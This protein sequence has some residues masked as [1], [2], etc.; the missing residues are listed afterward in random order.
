[1]RALARGLRQQ[2]YAVDIAADGEAGWEAG[3]VHEYDLVILDLNLPAMDG[4]EVCRR[5][6][7]CKPELLILILTARGRLEDRVTGL[8]LGADDYLVKPFHWYIETIA[9]VGYRSIPNESNETAHSA[10]CAGDSPS[11]SSLALA[12]NTVGGQ[13]GSGFGSRTG[14]F[15]LRAGEEASRASEPLCS[16]GEIRAINGVALESSYLIAKFY[17]DTNYR[18]LLVEYYGASACSS[19]VSYGVTSLPANLDNRFASGETFSNCNLLSVYDFA[20]YG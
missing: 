1:M 20:N 18:T 7:A 6:R 9:G 3:E 5:L 16:T 13:T 11:I 15:H 10:R 12:I 17:D 19:T 2:G 8:D 14:D 4:L